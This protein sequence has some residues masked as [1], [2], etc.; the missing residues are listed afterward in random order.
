LQRILGVEP[1]FAND[2]LHSNL[3]IE[4][5]ATTPGCCKLRGMI[6]AMHICSY[7][8][9]VWYALWILAGI[10]TKRAVERADWGRALGY[11]IPVLLGYYLMFGFD[12]DVPWLQ[13]RIIPRTQPIGIAAILI[14]LA[15]MAF[16]TWARVYLGRNWSSVPTIKEQHQLI[17]GGPYRLVR[18]PIYTGILLAMVGTSLANGKVRGLLSIL[19]LWIGWT[20]KSRMEEEFMV[21]TF[22]AEYEEYRRATG[23]LIP[24]ILS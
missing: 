6:N 15:G 8:W 5:E 3:K 12:F 1:W 19:V 23:A 20:V 24:R 11:Y 16:A 10:G 7:L 4:P 14:T 17:R 22:G 18:H 9:L 2:S 13:Y 21:R